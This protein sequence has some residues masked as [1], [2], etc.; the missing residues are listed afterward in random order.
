MKVLELMTEHTV[1]FKI[2]IEVLKELLPETNIEFISDEVD[3]TGTEEKE[4]D[5]KNKKSTKKKP[6]K[7]GKKKDDSDAEVESDSE[8]RKD[9]EITEN[10][11]DTSKNKKKGGMKI[12]AIDTTKNVL[13][14]LKLDS[15]NFTTFECKKKRLVLG[16]NLTYFH[17]LIKTMD[18]DDNLTLYVDHDDMNYMKIKIDNPEEKKDSVFEL[19]LLDLNEAELAIPDITFD[20][21]ITMNSAEFH[22]LCREMSQIADYVEIK[23]FNNKIIFTC[24]GDYA[25]RT[26]TYRTGDINGG[27]DGINIKLANTKEPAT[28]TKTK[29]SKKTTQQ[30]PSI[31]I[32]GIYDLRNLVMFSKCSSLCNEIEIFMKNDYP[33]VIKYTV[34]TLGRILL[35]LVPKTEESIKNSNYSDDEEYYNEEQVQLIK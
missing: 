6:V 30:T 20:A 12:M 8:N 14:H 5:S 13:I 15:E 34:A 31:I 11:T 16:V 32:Q 19:K 23:C 26:T 29:D 9:T 4:K 21:V 27:G 2:L 24:K 7:K 22:K 28:N 17:K 18:K 35:C 33:I 3:K 1:P 25:K 10:E